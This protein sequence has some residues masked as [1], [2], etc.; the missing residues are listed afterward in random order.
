MEGI[1]K[2]IELLR[3]HVCDL[4]NETILVPV[5]YYSLAYHINK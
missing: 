1:D 5:R 3:H 2:S 4:F